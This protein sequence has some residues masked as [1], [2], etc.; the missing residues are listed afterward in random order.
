M[1]VQTIIDIGSTIGSAIPFTQM[2]LKTQRKLEILINNAVNSVRDYLRVRTGFLKSQFDFEIQGD[3]VVLFI[4]DI[5][6]Y[7]QYLYA[8]GERF[9]D[10]WIN[11]VNAFKRTLKLSFANQKIPTFDLNSAFDL[12]IYLEGFLTE[13]NKYIKKEFTK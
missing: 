4:D 13:K 11:L 7:A 12:F 5:V 3:K 8:P 10:E 2:P 6:P 1:K 9:Y